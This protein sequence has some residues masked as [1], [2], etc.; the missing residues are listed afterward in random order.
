MLLFND[1]MLFGYHFRIKRCSARLY[2]RLFVRG[3][4]SYLRYL[5]L[6]AHSGVF[7]F[8]LSS[9]YVCS[10]DSF[11]GLPI[12]DAFSHSENASFIENV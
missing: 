6:F 2:L 1:L 3:L 9:S 11:S 10:I 4:M 12:N 7:S 5:C 8:C